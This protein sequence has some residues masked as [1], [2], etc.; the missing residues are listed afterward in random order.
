VLVLLAS[1][2]A[3][4]R[5]NSDA[6]GLRALSSARLG[7]RDR[8][9]CVGHRVDEARDDEATKRNGCTSFSRALRPPRGELGN[10]RATGGV[11]VARCRAVPLLGSKREG[12]MAFGRHI[13]VVEDDSDLREAIRSVLEDDGFEVTSSD[14]GDDALEKLR[15]GGLRLVL[16]D[17]GLKRM[18]GREFMA[19]Q[20][21]EPDLR[22]TPVVLLSGEADLSTVARR[23]GAVGHLQKPFDAE[24]L[25]AVA[26]RLCPLR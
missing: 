21:R 17:L 16:L 15:S 13:L 5:E 26:R 1:C 8:T 23:L 14:D 4:R 22:R 19:N 2:Q 7:A 24:D 12:I 3:T 11:L 10:R 9:D 20:E 25:L 6:R 18:S